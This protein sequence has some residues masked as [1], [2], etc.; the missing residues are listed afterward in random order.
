MLFGGSGTVIQRTLRQVNASTAVV[1]PFFS[2]VPGEL[3][4]IKRKLSLSMAC[5][6]LTCRR[7]FWCRGS[8]EKKIRLAEFCFTDRD[9]GKQSKQEAERNYHTDKT[10]NAKVDHADR[11]LIHFFIIWC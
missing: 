7:I 10:Q 6:M 5:R 4:K 9:F 1:E 11:D 3:S 2:P 8:K